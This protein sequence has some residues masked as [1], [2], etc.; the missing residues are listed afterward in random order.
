MRRD[1][2]VRPAATHAE[3]DA[4][5]VTHTYFLAFCDPSR[6]AGASIY[7]Q[8]RTMREQPR[9][10]GIRPFLIAAAALAACSALVPPPECQAHETQ[11]ADALKAD[12]LFALL[13]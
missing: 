1:L 9:A 12:Y 4:R 5:I 7:E 8:W 10:R 11:R 6:K 2:N 3:R 13:K